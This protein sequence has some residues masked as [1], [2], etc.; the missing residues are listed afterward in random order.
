MGEVWISICESSSDVESD[1]SALAL[2][3][4]VE[5]GWWLVGCW[6]CVACVPVDGSKVPTREEEIRVTPFYYMILVIDINIC[7]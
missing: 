2:R 3:S 6:A 7:C 5:G 1:K 4:F